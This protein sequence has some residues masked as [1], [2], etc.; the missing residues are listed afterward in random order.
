MDLSWSFSH[1]CKLIPEAFWSVGWLSPSIGNGICLVALRKPH[2]KSQSSTRDSCLWQSQKGISRPPAHSVTP[3]N[4]HSRTPMS[5]PPQPALVKVQCL[6]RH[7]D[8][9]VWDFKMYLSRQ[10]YVRIILQ[11]VTTRTVHMELRPGRIW[12]VEGSL[13]PWQSVQEAR[14][15]KT[16]QKIYSEVRR[17]RPHSV[18]THLWLSAVAASRE[19]LCS[20]RQVV[21]AL[22]QM[23]LP[24]S[25]HLDFKKH[26]PIESRL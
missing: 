4:G 18:G 8:S 15:H 14:S 25:A 24:K 6:L 12:G 26:V 2:N 20:S 16:P 23:L 11:G 21:Q 19:A 1:M 5:L 7:G 9:W 13:L 10:I 22:F 3:L 17:P